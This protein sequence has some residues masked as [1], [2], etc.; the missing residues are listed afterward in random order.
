MPQVMRQARPKMLARAMIAT[1]G[2]L[3]SESS[4]GAIRHASMAALNSSAEMM[5]IARGGSS[6]AASRCSNNDP[7]GV[8]GMSASPRSCHRING[9]EAGQHEASAGVT[10]TL[11]S[12][13]RRARTRRDSTQCNR[14]WGSACRMASYTAGARVGAVREAAWNSDLCSKCRILPFGVDTPQHPVLCLV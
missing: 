10:L 4:L 5:P 2:D 13:W 12:L 11:C 9:D 6:Q 14:C 1:P 3:E 8:L 7:S